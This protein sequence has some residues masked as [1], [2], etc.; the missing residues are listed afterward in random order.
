[1]I[2]GTK[3]TV[4]NASQVGTA[5]N[6][7]AGS[8]I[9][10]YSVPSGKTFILTDLVC[11]WNGVDNITSGNSTPGIALID[12]SYGGST[13]GTYTQAKVMFKQPG[14]HAGV[15]TGTVQTLVVTGLQNGPGFTTA[16]SALNLSTMLTIPAYGVKAVGYLV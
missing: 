3:V 15:A 1:M 10:M 6:N 16:V 5:G 11:D 4:R 2:K 9:T 14:N 7:T 13:V 12:A 8:A